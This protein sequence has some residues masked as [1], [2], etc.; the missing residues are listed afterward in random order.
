MN[1]NFDYL[2]E[3]KSPENINSKKLDKAE[4]LSKT[5]NSPRSERKS[6][7]STKIEKNEDSKKYTFTRHL[8]SCNNSATQKFGYFR[9]AFNKF[10]EPGVSLL[11]IITGLLMD[12]HY[13]TEPYSTKLSPSKLS[14]VKLSSTR[15]YVSCLIRTWITAIIL[16][17]PQCNGEFE[18]FI[19]PFLKEKEMFQGF[20]I[21]SGNMPI[22]T[23]QQQ[24]KM[25][26]FFFENLNK[27]LTYCIQ[28]QGDR[29]FSTITSKIKEIDAKKHKIKFIYLQEDGI[30]D[31]Q[32]YYAKMHM[33]SGE[34]IV[35]YMGVSGGAKSHSITP[36]M[37]EQF[38]GD[39]ITLINDIVI[40]FTNP[41][42]VSSLEFNGVLDLNYTLPRYFK[43]SKYYENG[44][45]LFTKWLE[46]KDI[47]KN[48][49]VV[50]HSNLMKQSIKIVCKK[51]C[52]HKK[53]AIDYIDKTN[54]CDLIIHGNDI[55]LKTN[56][57]ESIDI[58][59]KLK[60]SNIDEDFIPCHYGK[61][62]QKIEYE[63]K[64]KLDTRFL[65]RTRDILKRKFKT[66]R[67]FFS[68]GGTKRLKHKR[69]THRRRFPGR[70]SNA[71][72]SRRR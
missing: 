27:I 42:N 16:Y 24:L 61:S 68:N 44:L 38:T 33:N 56:G 10:P 22:Y 29:D 17:L 15:V 3:S 57:I 60:K 32:L 36:E 23:F 8:F 69:R 12:A 47:N 45:F 46:T 51:S 5:L 6:Q 40:N 65:A 9:S 21:D 31:S 55:T 30:P 52:N 14:P 66:F 11:G 53:T 48:I 1:N 50:T 39:D 26:D 41:T 70:R 71:R 34:K 63:S 72:F 49:Y 7:S 20:S 64:K 18:L 43:Y 25:L 28:N 58:Y 54:A 59:N 19:S 62:R 37:M 4:N 2:S 13:S 35:E 67:R